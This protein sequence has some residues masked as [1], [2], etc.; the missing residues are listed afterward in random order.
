MQGI[1]EICPKCGGHAWS[2]TDF[3]E[4]TQELRCVNPKCGYNHLQY[5]DEVH[6]FYKE[7][8]ETEEFIK[9]YDL[10]EELEDLKN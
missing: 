2:Y 10:E 1:N 5:G 3:R 7:P 9:D 4:Q 6:E 8:N